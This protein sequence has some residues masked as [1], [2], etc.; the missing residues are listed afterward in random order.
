MKCHEARQHL[1]L[2]LD[3][4]GD[5]DLHFRISDHLA[6]CTECADWFAK[7]E[8]WERALAERLAAGASTPALWDRVLTRAG[9]AAPLVPRRGWL[10]FGGMLAA[11]AAVWVVALAGIAR[12]GR[13]HG[14]ELATMAAGWHERWAEGS[15]KPD[16]VSGSDEQ[17]E[18]YLKRHLPFRVHCPPRKDV[19]FAV[20]GAGVHSV[21]DRLTAHI[22][23]QVGEAPV[24][25]FVL[26]RDS[27]EAFPDER[28][29]ITEGGGR[30][31]CREGNYQMVS[32]V[33]ADNLVVV[34][35][36]A[37]PE[38]LD[39]LISAYGSYHEA[40]T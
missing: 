4:E 15:L 14:S 31:R 22:V 13:S 9:I 6:M 37:S 17:V 1:M 30:H 2:Y 40:S 7:E 33:I 5:A 10:V 38:A 32:S 24:S 39:K 25:I 20:A 11:A 35:G 18:T 29:R 16:L 12:Q 3:S 19:D 21:K 36:A 34:M 28:D 26:S 27:L 8:R 23:G